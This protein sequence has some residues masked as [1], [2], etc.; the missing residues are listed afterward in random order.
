[1]CLAVIAGSLIFVD[2]SWL[3]SVG[4]S[5]ILVQIAVVL[6][7]WPILGLPPW[8]ADASWID[9]LGRG[10][11]WGWIVAAASVTVLGFL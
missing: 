9:R 5:L 2:L 6:L 10:V 11:G 8:H 3:T 4:D 7:L 1:M